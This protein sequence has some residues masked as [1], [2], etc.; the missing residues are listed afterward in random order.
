MSPFVFDLATDHLCLLTKK[1]NRRSRK[2]TSRNLTEPANLL[3]DGPQPA[4]RQA[5]ETDGDG[6][7]SS[8]ESCVNISRP[9]H[10]TRQERESCPEQ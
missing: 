10:G 7:Q 9:A 5:R 8:S 2:Y 1:E 4:K 6:A 3:E